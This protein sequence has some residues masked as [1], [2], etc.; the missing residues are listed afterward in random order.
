MF[1]MDEDFMFA[2]YGVTYDDLYDCRNC[3]CSKCANCGEGLCYGNCYKGAPACV[4]YRCEGFENY[5]VVN[6]DE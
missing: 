3:L 1:D 5:K 6:V 2:V 4:T